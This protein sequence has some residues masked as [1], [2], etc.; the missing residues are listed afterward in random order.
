MAA[1]VTK[2]ADSKMSKKAECVDSDVTSPDS[3]TW[4]RF[5]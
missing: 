1:S 4:G 5:N 3:D 2:A